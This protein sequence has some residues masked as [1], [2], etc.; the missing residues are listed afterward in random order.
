MTKLILK[1]YLILIL[2]FAFSCVNT[3][4]QNELSYDLTFVI[5]S[6]RIEDFLKYPRNN[7]KLNELDY[8]TKC[9]PSENRN[10]N[11]KTLVGRKYYD[12]EYINNGKKYKFR[13]G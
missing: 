2:L 8:E 12:C 1:I 10:P 5:D 13:L 3:R 9:K 6:T 4:K 11:K 7:L